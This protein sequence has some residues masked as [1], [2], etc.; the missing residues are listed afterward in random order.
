MTHHWPCY[1]K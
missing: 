1:I